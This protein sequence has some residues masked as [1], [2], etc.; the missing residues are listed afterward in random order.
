M[1]SPVWRAKLCGEIG[2]DKGKLLC[3]DE[4]DAT[5][6]TKVVALGNGATVTIGEGLEELIEIVRMV[7]R[8]QVEAIQDDMEDALLDRLTVEWCGRI[9]TISGS[10]LVRLEKASRE[11]ALR[12]FD[13]FAECQG[14]MDVSEEVLGSLLDDDALVTESQVR[15][16]K[17]ILR[18]MKGGPGGVTRGEGLLRK[19]QIPLTGLLEGKVRMMRHVKLV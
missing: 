3:L 19:I 1:L 6:F 14:F 10:G 7:D 12:E 16:L 17:N 13:D 11:L 9:L 4:E 2:A 15:M 5:L 18:W 8:Y